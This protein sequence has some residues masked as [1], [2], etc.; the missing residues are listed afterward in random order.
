M[1][2]AFAG[3]QRDAGPSE[4][5]AGVRH[6]GL[7]I[8]VELKPVTERRRAGDLG[9]YRPGRKGQADRNAEAV[10]AVGGRSGLKRKADGLASELE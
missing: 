10:R 2:Q 8:A 6:L 7:H 4:K 3:G 9:R 5:V 1:L